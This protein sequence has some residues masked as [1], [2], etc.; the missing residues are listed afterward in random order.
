MRIKI[1]KCFFGDILAYWSA[2]FTIEI[3]FFEWCY[4]VYLGRNPVPGGVTN[5]FRGLATIFP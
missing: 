3:I 2:S 5:V 1:P 4:A